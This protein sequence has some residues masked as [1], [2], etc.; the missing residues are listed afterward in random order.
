MK[1]AF[2]SDVHFPYHGVKA[3]NL[4]LDILSHLEIDSIILGGD[5]ID[6]E[7][8]SR[9][10]EHPQRKLDLKPQ[11]ETSRRQLLR[12]RRAVGDIPITFMEGNHEYRMARYLFQRAPELVG[13]DALSVQ[14]LLRLRDSDLDISWIDR[15]QVLNLGKLPVVHGDQIRAG[16]VNT[17]RSIYQKIGSNL[18]VGHYHRFDRYFHRLYNDSTHGVWVNG[19]LCDLNPEYVFF[20]QWFQG[21][22]IVEVAKNSMFTVEQVI[23]FHQKSKLCALVHDT[24]YSN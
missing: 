23:Y 12:L 11:I 2:L 3:W 18:L 8:V 14:E 1:A 16:Y 10:V 17:A 5:I 24:F 13:I 7:P 15:T 4:T 20:P 9:F 22:T 6:F 21:F 19:C